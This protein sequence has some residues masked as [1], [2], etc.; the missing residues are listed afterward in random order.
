MTARPSVCSGGA[1]AAINGAEK[2]SSG[3]NGRAELFCNL[4]VIGY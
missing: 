1:A 2:R 4:C 3:G